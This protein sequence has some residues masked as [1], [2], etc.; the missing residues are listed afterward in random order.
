[1]KKEQESIANSKKYRED[2]CEL[3]NKFG[4]MYVEKFKDEGLKDDEFVEMGFHIGVNFLC[5]MIKNYVSPESY[6]EVLESVSDALKSG[7]DHL[8]KKR[9]K[10]E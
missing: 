4:E 6:C 9:G 3:V 7:V 1:M 10:N 2:I 8:S 5:M